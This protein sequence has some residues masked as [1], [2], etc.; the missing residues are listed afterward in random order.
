MQKLVVAMLL[1]T[2]VLGAAA[3]AQAA[4][5]AQVQSRAAVSIAVFGDAPYGTSNADTAQFLA[6]P[7]FIQTINADQSLSLVIHVGDIHSGK[8]LC[9]KAYDQSIFD[10]WKSFQQPL[11]YTPGDNEWADCQKSGEIGGE[12]DPL[13]NLGYVRDIFFANPGHTIAVDQPVLSQKTNSSG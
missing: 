2:S 13:V 10:M 1:A 3:P 4:P 12:R 5:P 9:S 7:A 11:V 6:T 8:Q